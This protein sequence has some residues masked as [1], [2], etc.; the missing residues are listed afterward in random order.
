MLADN[1]NG[2]PAKDAEQKVLE[3]ENEIL[4]IYEHAPMALLLLNEE[5]RITKYNRILA[6]EL[7]PRNSSTFYGH[8]VGEA[9]SCRFLTPS[10][11]NSLGKRGKCNL[12]NECPKCELRKTISGTMKTGIPVRHQKCM[13]HIINN[14]KQ[15]EMIFIV[16]VS[17]LYIDD[18]A[19][20]FVSLTDITDKISLE[21][22]LSRLQKLD[23]I[24]QLAGGIAHDFN[25]LL[26]VIKGYAQLVYSS[27]PQDNKERDSIAEI[28]KAAE[29]GASLTSQLLAFSRRQPLKLKY[30][31]LNQLIQNSISMIG[32][33]FP[34]NIDVDFMPGNELGVIHLDPVQ[35][36]QILMN[37]CLNARDA[38]P[39]GGLLSIETENIRLNGAYC[40][41]H[42][43]ATP[44]HYVLLTVTDN[45]IGMDDETLTHI[46]EPFFS[47][48]QK[49]G[50]GLGLATVYG[51]VKQQHGMINVYSEKNKGT[52]F[53]IYFPVVE[54]DASD[55]GTKLT[56]PLV[57]GKGECVLAAD[58]DAAILR[59][60][61]NMLKKSGYEVITASDGE[62]ALRK[63]KDNDGKIALLLLDV[64]MPKKGGVDVFN[65][66]KDKYPNLKVIFSSGYTDNVIHK[67]H[68]LDD[69][70]EFIPKPYSE[71]DLLRK[72]RSVLDK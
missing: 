70:V 9:L 34:K 32:P 46:F 29:T 66:L 35:M 49:G 16:S 45:G 60:L 20:V 53:K 30:V 68:I 2:L 27:L 7:A 63:F 42:V 55:I 23:T 19:H 39:N 21:K 31:N 58:D 28:C 25:N 40:K 48:K 72:I 13:L 47:A 3:T 8:C 43:E 50:T 18:K 10:A 36:E 61:Q 15:H 71:E 1:K 17:R 51:I 22:Q 59:L 56:E 54:A 52:T 4:A 37:L 26:Q 69:T 41:T 44:G 12:S 65:E 6:D 24:G 38:M 11:H 64:V 5:L 57:L 33:L 62:E 67:E 14:G